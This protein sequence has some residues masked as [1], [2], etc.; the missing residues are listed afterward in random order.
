MS[1]KEVKAMKYLDRIRKGS[2]EILSEQ[3]QYQAEDNKLQLEAD[4]RETQRLLKS[5]QRRLEELKSQPQLSG[6]NIIECQ[7]MIAGLTAGVKA[8]GD[9]IH[10]LF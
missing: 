5:E 8:L 10:E 1:K 4:L 6:G 3:Q 2:E 7:D 9:L